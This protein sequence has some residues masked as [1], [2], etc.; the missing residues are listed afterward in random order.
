MTQECLIHSHRNAEIQCHI[1][2]EYFCASCFES[3]EGLEFCL[4][5][6]KI[7]RK[8]QWE[9]KEEIECTSAQSELAVE[10]VDRK[11]HLYQTQRKLGFIKT[12]L[13]IDQNNNIVSHLR[14]YQPKG[15]LK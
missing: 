14:W 15:S 13:K 7:I 8:L 2:H 5:H 12:E 3:L 9:V 4:E 1:C 11:I 6:A 10:M